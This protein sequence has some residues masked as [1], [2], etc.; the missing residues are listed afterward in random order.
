MGSPKHLL[1]LQ[2]ETLIERTVAFLTSL[3]DPPM[4]VGNGE[5]PNTL[6]H[7]HRLKDIPLVKGPLGGLLAVMEGAGDRSVLAMAC[8]TPLVN[9]LALSWLLKTSASQPDA[10]AVIPRDE[11]GR[12]QPLFALYRPAILPSMRRNAEHGILGLYHLAELEKVATPDVPKTIADR[13]VNI[14]TPGELDRIKH[15]VEGS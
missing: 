14:N 2:G 3:I 15:T 4:V 12:H 11:T 13:L 1:R 5:L 7:L 6:T 10:W 9:E 8:D